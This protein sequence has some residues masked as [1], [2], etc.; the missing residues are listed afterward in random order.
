MNCTPFDCPFEWEDVITVVQCNIFGAK[1]VFILYSIDRC[2]EIIQQQPVQLFALFTNKNR[3]SENLVYRKRSCESQPMIL[4]NFNIPN[5]FN[6][7]VVN[8]FIL[9]V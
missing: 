3:N 7:F 6:L 8:F 5:Q 4:W 9:Q 1:N 2:T